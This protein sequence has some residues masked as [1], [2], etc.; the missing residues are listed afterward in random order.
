MAAIPLVVTRVGDFFSVLK[1]TSELVRMMER[2]APGA[3][4]RLTKLGVDDTISS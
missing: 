2:V 4:S 1:Q 3:A